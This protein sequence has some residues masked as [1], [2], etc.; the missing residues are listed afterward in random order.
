[1]NPLSKFKKGAIIA[2]ILYHAK[3]EPFYGSWFKEELEKHGYKISYGTLY[4]WLSKLV[5]SGYLSMEKKNVRGKIRKYYSITDS[6]KE[7]FKE[8]KKFLEELYKE[9][10]EK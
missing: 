2:H 6:G 1:M 7:H 9:V 10:M 3:K 4:P 8:I 5:F